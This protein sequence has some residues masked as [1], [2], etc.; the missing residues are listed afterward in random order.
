MTFDHDPHSWLEKKRIVQSDVTIQRNDCSKQ[1]SF[2]LNRSDILLN[3]KHARWW[4]KPMKIHNNA[5]PQK[6][7]HSAHEL[8]VNMYI[9]AHVCLAQ[10]LPPAKYVCH[11]VV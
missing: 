4:P 1:F 7:E 2:F 3:E 8:T 6:E 9:H 5:F 11:S 10:L